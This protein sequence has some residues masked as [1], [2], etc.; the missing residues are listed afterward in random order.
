L[1]NLRGNTFE[2]GHKWVERMPLASSFSFV[3]NNSDK[4][5]GN[6]ITDLSHYLQYGCK[7]SVVIIKEN[8]TSKFAV[9]LDKK[10]KFP[11]KY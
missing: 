8:K 2:M 5:T 6:D 3:G 7:A 1:D 11:V 10:S 9:C 4:K